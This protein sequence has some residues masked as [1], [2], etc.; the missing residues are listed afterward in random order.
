M[1]LGCVDVT[2]LQSVEMRVREAYGK[3]DISNEGM[4]EIAAEVLAIGSVDVSEIYSPPR[5]C[6]AASALGLKPGFSADLLVPKTDGEN[7]D[8]SR[9]EDERELERLQLIEEPTLL[10]GGRLARR[11][12]SRGTSARL[13]ATPS[14]RR[15]SWSV[16]GIIYA[17][18]P[19]PTSVSLGQDA[20]SSTRRH[21]RRVHGRSRKS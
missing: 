11:S 8:L 3:I 1:N 10:C 18:L 7:W 17:W 20:T 12:R 6:A 14:R 21:G 19:V 16:D 15:R 5:F 13:G 9:P 4:K 2:S